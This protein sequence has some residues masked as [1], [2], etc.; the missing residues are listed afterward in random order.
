M[1]QVKIK[2]FLSKPT[3]P[4]DV[5]LSRMLETLKSKF[6]K[7]IQITVSGND[8]DLFKMYNLTG[9]PAGCNIGYMIFA[10]RQTF[11]RKKEPAKEDIE[12]VEI[13]GKSPR[14][15]DL[16]YG[17]SKKILTGAFLNAIFLYTNLK[18]ASYERFH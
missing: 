18:D 14:L 10:N 16:A 11:N 1:G 13:V 4:G 2:A 12:E 5:R 8:D 7:K 9:T 6:G 3:T 15:K 17:D